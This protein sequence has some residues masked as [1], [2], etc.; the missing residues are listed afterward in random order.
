MEKIE[1]FF[2]ACKKHT[3]YQNISPKPDNFQ[4]WQDSE[5][6]TWKYARWIQKHSNVSTLK[7]DIA[8]PNLEK[9]VKEANSVIKDAIKHRGEIHPGWRSVTL[10]GAGMHIT[11]D[12]NAE[13]YQGKWDQR[14]QYTWTE[15]AE[16]CPATV[17]WL[18]THWSW[19]EFHRIRFMLLEPGGAI[20][21]H[22]D[23]DQRELGAINVAITNPPGIEFGMEEAGTVPWRPG[24]V[25]AIDIG[26][27]HAVRNIGSHNRI[28]MIIHGVP[29]YKHYQ[30]LCRSYE[31]LHRQIR[32]SWVVL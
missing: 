32:H 25:R 6:L 12:W 4:G 31:E 3:H 10:H 1:K 24:D 13:I 5:E 26:R 22:Q 11:E 18:Q 15:I 20:Q 17:E 14:P 28:H 8:I 21:P 27:Q 16:Q 30:T 7:L 29:D 19:Q 2:I 9:I 23:M